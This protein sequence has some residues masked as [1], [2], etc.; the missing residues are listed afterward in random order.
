MKSGTG[1]L[2]CL[3]FAISRTQGEISNVLE[4]DTSTVTEVESPT[5]FQNLTDYTWDIH[6]TEL[7]SGIEAKIAFDDKNNFS[8]G[9]LG[10]LR[11]QSSSMIPSLE[12]AVR[13]TGPLSDLTLQYEVREPHTGQSSYT[14]TITIVGLGLSDQVTITY[15][16]CAPMLCTSLHHTVSLTLSLVPLT[17]SL[18]LESTVLGNTLTLQ[19]SV[20]IPRESANIQGNYDG[21]QFHLDLELAREEMETELSVS[22]DME[23]RITVEMA[24]NRWPQK[25]SGKAVWEKDGQYNH[26]DLYWLAD[27]FYFKLDAPS[28]LD[29]VLQTISTRTANTNS[30]RDWVYNSGVWWIPREGG[31]AMASTV[32]GD[33]VMSAHGLSFTFH[34]W[35]GREYPLDIHWRDNSLVRNSL[36]VMIEADKLTNFGILWDFVDLNKGQVFYKLSEDNQGKRFDV[37]HELRWDVAKGAVKS[38]VFYVEGNGDDGTPLPERREEAVQQGLQYGRVVSTIET[39]TGGGMVTKIDGI[40]SPKNLTVQGNLTYRPRP[41]PYLSTILAGKVGD[42]QWKLID[43]DDILSVETAQK[44]IDNILNNLSQSNGLALLRGE[45]F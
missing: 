24:S 8:K 35:L 42:T 10:Y 41:Q 7:Q 37:T 45:L 43:Q 5:L 17:P 15:Q 19:T 13:M 6:F 11:V 40:Y 33:Y 23:A 38:R 9:G 28:L 25:V 44:F 39:K 21:K 22:G 16:D 4:R 26:L 34:D 30:I 3:L 29:G 27:P 32:I 36:D 20:N 2:L 12:A 18:H 1:F 31:E 14:G